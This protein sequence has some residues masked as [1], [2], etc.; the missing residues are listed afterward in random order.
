MDSAD[1]NNLLYGVAAAGIGFSLVWLFLDRRSEKN[2]G[3]DTKSGTPSDRP[4]WQV[5][6]LP[7]TASRDQ[8]R[9]AYWKKM[10]EF[11]PNKLDQLGPELRPLAEIRAQAIK[12]AFEQSEQRFNVAANARPS[13]VS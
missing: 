1:I 12:A 2:A 11:Q 4:W 6:D 8:T 3:A 9:T 13:T 10:Q 5:L 7:P